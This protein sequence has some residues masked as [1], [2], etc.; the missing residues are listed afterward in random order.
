[1]KSVKNS[2]F[3]VLTFY[4]FQHFRCFT[5]E[6]RFAKKRAR[7][8]IQTLKFF[9]IIL[10][11]KWCFC[12]RRFCALF[13]TPFYPEKPFTLGS[14]KVTFCGISPREFAHF[15]GPPPSHFFLVFSPFLV[16]LQFLVFF[17]NGLKTVPFFEKWLSRGY[18]DFTKNH[19]KSSFGVTFWSKNRSK[20]VKKPKKVQ[21]PCVWWTPPAQAKKFRLFQKWSRLFCALFFDLF[22]ICFLDVFFDV[23]LIKKV[24]FL[25]LSH[26]LVLFFL[27][28]LN[29][30]SLFR[31][32]WVQNRV[33]RVENRRFW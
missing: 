30:Q 32:F 20:N 24:R 31:H 12:A 18:L 23:F 10:L 8:E 7:V 2:V 11:R 3:G 28:K 33:W 21:K 22:S 14:K 19:Q 9:S 27:K 26:N 16:F 1:M 4:C 6:G 15:F 5:K 25:K 13:W 17:G 29:F